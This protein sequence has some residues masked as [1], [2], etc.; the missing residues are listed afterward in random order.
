M[1]SKNQPTTHSAP[2]EADLPQ[3]A[4]EAGRRGCEVDTRFLR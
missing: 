3:I 4:I 2:T 1:A